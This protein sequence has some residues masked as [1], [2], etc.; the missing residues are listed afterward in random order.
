[1]KQDAILLNNL[2]SEFKNKEI[3]VK[4][5]KP[6]MYAKEN[7][8]K[9][10]L[11]IDLY[12]MVQ[13]KCVKILSYIDEDQHNLLGA[14]G[15]VKKMKTQIELTI[16]TNTNIWKVMV[17]KFTSDNIDP[18][19]N[20][21][22]NIK[23]KVHTIL[24]NYIYLST[25]KP[26]IFVCGLQTLQHLYVG[27]NNNNFNNNDN[28]NIKQSNIIH[29]YVKE[30]IIKRFH[31]ARKLIYTKLKEKI[32]SENAY[33]V[34][35][36]ENDDEEEV[37][38][39]DDIL[40]PPSVDATEVLIL[41][42]DMLKNDLVHVYQTVKPCFPPKFDIYHLCLAI[43]CNEY[44]KL[45][46]RTNMIENIKELSLLNIMKLIDRLRY[47]KYKVY[48]IESLFTGSSNNSDH[49]NNDKEKLPPSPPTESFKIVAGSYKNNDKL[50]PLAS[51]NEILEKLIF[52]HKASIRNQMDAF[53]TNVASKL[54]TESSKTRLLNDAGAVYTKEPQDILFFMHHQID[55]CHNAKLHSI[56]INRVSSVCFI[57]LT[58]YGTIQ[59]EYLVENW[60]DSNAVLISTNVRL[61]INDNDKLIDNCL[62]FVDNLEEEM[63]SQVDSNIANNKFIEKEKMT[64]SHTLKIAA[65]I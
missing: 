45:F 56:D 50:V 44:D 17:K 26:S 65:M 58:R 42:L 18:I 39:D 48:E 29:V 33:D 55:V 47:F 63:E 7:I 41:Q 5:L 2:S 51:I 21:E 34:G 36:E 54:W 20:V 3:N 27:D 13:T 43:Y 38:G 15:E 32:D 19:L 10:Q 52:Q 23:D 37:D 31:N 28:Y 49:Y 62:N 35:D 61:S 60:H 11:Y 46:L 25:N 57:Q 4:L 30:G 9:F 53:I 1:M 24:I 8:S 40:T 14:I 59:F 6:V 12:D 64:R 16:S 22:N